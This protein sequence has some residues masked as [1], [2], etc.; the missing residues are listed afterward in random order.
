MVNLQN[1]LHLFESDD[2]GE[3]WS[4]IST[5]ITPGDESKVIELADGSWMVNSRVADAG[6]RYVHISED[7]GKTWISR[8]DSALVDP[9]CNASIIRYSSVKDGDDRNRL[10]F[11]NANSAKGRLNMTVRISYDEGLTWSKGK[12][13]YEEGSAYSSL[14]VLGNGDIGLFFEK[15]F[16]SENTFVSFSLEW[17]TDGRD[18]KER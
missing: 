1:G 18:K 2:H 6:L 14:T 17:L 10:L 4:F 11:A 7:E 8:P 13:I 9:A 3:T 16:Y 15:D 12:T 5:A